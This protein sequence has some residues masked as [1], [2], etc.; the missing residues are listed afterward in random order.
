MDRELTLGSLFSGSGGFELGG[1]LCGIRPVF[2][3]EVE[4]FP[5]RVTTKRLPD[6]KHIGDINRIDGAKVTPVDILTAGFC[7]QDLSVAGKRAG[8]HGERSGLFFQ[9]TRIIA[10]M[11]AAT[12]NEYPR[13][14]V[15]E[16]VPGML[17]SALFLV[18]ILSNRPCYLLH[19]E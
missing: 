8:L 13:F 5:I 1:L 3:S 18:K 11:L 15:L 6:V 4:P 12:N 16:N 10:E 19:S 7:C 9:I 2:A 17:T 14:A